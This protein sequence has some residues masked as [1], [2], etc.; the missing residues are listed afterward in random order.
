MDLE[1]KFETSVNFQKARINPRVV[2]EGAQLLM[3]KISPALVEATKSAMVVLG[4]VNTG[5]T[6]R[7]IHSRK[8][9]SRSVQGTG[10]G[11]IHRQVVGNKVL[12][13]IIEG[14]EAGQPMPVRWIRKGKRGNI[15]TPLP[16]ML[17]W[18]LMN[19]IPRESWFPIMRDIAING[20]QPKN[21]PARAVRIALPA[22]R[23]HSRWAG[24]YIARGIIQRA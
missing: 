6:Q 16:S 8:V 14:R 1:Y 11:L 10:G 18:F 5:R 22:I 4:A 23:T 2:N 17:K 7:S 13:E 12:G 24:M 19:G 3:D 21:I 15:F 20:I 9:A